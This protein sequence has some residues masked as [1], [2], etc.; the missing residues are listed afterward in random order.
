[1]LYLSLTSDSG[2]IEMIPE[3]SVFVEASLE[4]LA[5]LT[6]LNNDFGREDVITTRASCYLPCSCHL[7]PSSL[8][9]HFHSRQQVD[10]DEGATG[11]FR[12]YS[13]EPH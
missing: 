3:H 11:L 5:R 7:T 9:P 2:Y 12:Y 8:L 4:Q 13:S 10:H 1:M 6:Y